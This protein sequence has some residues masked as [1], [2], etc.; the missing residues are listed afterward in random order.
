MVN[1]PQLSDD[2]GPVA[3]IDG[4]PPL[5]ELTATINAVC[6]EVEERQERS[7][8]VLQLAHVPRR[9]WPDA[10]SIQEVNRWE[11]A[12]RRF[13]RLSAVTIAVARGTCGGPAL[14]V[15]LAA[16]WRI[17]TPD[18]V[19]MLPVNDGHFWPGMAAYRL[20]QQLG[21]ARARQ[22]VLWGTDIP[23]DRAT[24]LGLIDQV[25]KDAVEGVRE[26]SV[27]AGRISDREF[28][29]RRQLLL[30]AGSA[31]YEAALGVHLAACDR[32]LRRLRDEALRPAAEN[33]S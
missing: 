3:V 14:D 2:L 1:T 20:V 10:D 18:L 26:A 22:I 12:V 4:S 27:L 19:L 17:G 25:S 9:E 7:V 24:D 21:L 15:L 13:E 29:I 33:A 23:L 31:E 5:W 16:D 11:R 30:E 8:V 32:E 6:D 28:S